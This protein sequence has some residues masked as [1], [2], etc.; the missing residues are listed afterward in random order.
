MLGV[1]NLPSS[2]LLSKTE[3]LKYKYKPLHFTLYFIVLYNFA[4]HSD[5]EYGLRVLRAEYVNNKRRNYQKNGENF[6]MKS[7][8]I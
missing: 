1:H 4:S 8:F 3:R 2:R 5:E 7:V 6:I